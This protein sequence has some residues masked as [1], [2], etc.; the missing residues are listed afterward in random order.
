MASNK[1][2]LGAVGS[3]G[4]GLL[5]LIGGL[6]VKHSQANLLA[7]CS[8]GLGQLGQAFDPNAATECSSAQDLSSMAVW[9]IWAGGIMLVLAVGGFFAVL[10]AGTAAA[11]GKSAGAAR[12]G[13]GS[14]P[15]AKAMP[16]TPAQT[17]ASGPAG[18]GCGHELKP[19][20]RFC[21]VCGRQA[22]S[23]GS[24][25]P[26]PAA[27]CGHEIRAGARFCAVCGRAAV[28]DAPTAALSVVPPEPARVPPEP[29]PIRSAPAPVPPAPVAAA[30]VPAAPVPAAPVPPSP[31][32]TVMAL[33][34]VPPWPDPVRPSS[35]DNV[36]DGSADRSY[37]GARPG[38]RP[39]YANPYPVPDGPPRHH[40]DRRPGDARRHHPRWLVAGGLMAILAAGGVA[41]VLILQPFRSSPA[42]AGVSPVSTPAAVAPSLSAAATPS[43][44][45]PRQSAADNLA[46]LL[47]QSVSERGSIVNA[48]SSVTEC[49]QNL[50]QDPQVLQSAAD[51]RRALLSRLASLPGR[52][53]L[54]ATMLQ[55]LASAWRASARA[56]QDFAQ[57]ANDELSQGCTPNDQSDPNFQAAAGPDARAT[58][59]K[60]AFVRAWNPI[61]TQYR[62]TSYSWDQL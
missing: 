19:G 44:Q 14:A 61:A 33:R 45:S 23:D 28:A 11:A 32:I 7:E 27:G 17:P 36:P 53:A 25:A 49:S 38:P 40:D 6:I 18:S 60:K 8:S 54:P 5:L 57:W 9:A 46:A 3:V 39:E 13:T 42:A 1:G 62:L 50:S 12:P 15:Q 35:P 34:P 4:T 2:A 21:T 22:A 26:A 58:A 30:P 24:G 10:A 16:A 47:G 37:G 48:V 29:A 55:Q 56:D 31:D 43:P 20:A 52:S 51:S 59:G 41:A